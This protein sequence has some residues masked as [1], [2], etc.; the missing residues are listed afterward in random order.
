MEATTAYSIQ[1]MEE[2][3]AS[4]EA[5]LTEAG[6]KLLS[7]NETDTQTLV[8]ALWNVAI[9]DCRTLAQNG[10]CVDKMETVLQACADYLELPLN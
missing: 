7:L 2:E 3:T 1:L 4:V 8:E 10:N 9:T 6:G 5:A